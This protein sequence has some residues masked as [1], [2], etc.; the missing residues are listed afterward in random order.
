MKDIEYYFKPRQSFEYPVRRGEEITPDK[1]YRTRKGER[2]RIYIK[3][4]EDLHGAIYINS[5]WQIDTWNLD[6]TYLKGHG[7]PHD[8]DIILSP[9][10]RLEPGKVYKS[11]D[12]RQAKVVFINEGCISDPV[13]GFIQEKDGY[14]YA[15]SW[16]ADGHVKR[17]YWPNNDLIAEWSNS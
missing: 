8:R 7:K 5:K 2:V 16:N 9:T 3:T 14:W 6:G 12:G 10:L 1:I 13:V 15:R 17:P 4:D 11:R